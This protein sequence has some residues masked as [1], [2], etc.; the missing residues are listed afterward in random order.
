MTSRFRLTPDK[1]WMP[2]HAPNVAPCL[3]AAQVILMD[4]HEKATLIQP[5]INEEE[6]V[7]VDFVSEK[8]LN[9]KVLDCTDQVVELELETAVPHMKQRVILPL[10]EIQVSEDRSHYTRD[11]DEPV[12]HSRLRISS[13][14]ERPK[15]PFH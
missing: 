2:G 4:S 12:R 10:R 15:G 3:P 11:P 7:T 8:D 14:Q 1:R 9:A 6:R 5:W 13:V